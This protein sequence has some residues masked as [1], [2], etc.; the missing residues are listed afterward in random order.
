M[1]PQTPR[2]S[3]NFTDGLAIGASFLSSNRLG[4]V[5]TAAVVIHEVPHEIGDFAILIRSGMSRRGA[6]IAQV[7]T[8]LG[9]V[10]GTVVGLVAH[11]FAQTSAWILP[12]TSGG[13]IYIACTTVLPDLLHDCSLAQSVREIGAMIVGVAM[14]VGIAFLE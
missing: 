13:F 14:M 11:Q 2:R 10:G 6:I 4:L 12:F 8:A 1:C 5:T 7:A 3:H 9:C